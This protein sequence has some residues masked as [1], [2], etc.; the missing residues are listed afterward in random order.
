MRNVIASPLLISV[1]SIRIVAMP[2]NQ[3]MRYGAPYL[4]FFWKIAGRRRIFAMPQHI[5]ATEQIIEFCVLT[6]AKRAAKIIHQRPGSPRSAV[7]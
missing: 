7:A 6:A 3:M 4:F 1:V 5:S 2:S